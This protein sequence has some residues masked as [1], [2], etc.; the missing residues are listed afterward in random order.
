MNLDFEQSITEIEQQIADLQKKAEAD[1]SNVK[2]DLSSLQKKL[3]AQIKKVYSELTPWQTVQV[4]RHPERPIMRDY[5][6]GMF[7]EF[8]DLHGDRCFGDDQ[9]LVGGFA[10]IGSHRCVLIGMDKGRTV[11]EKIKANFGMSNPDGYR[12]ALR[13]MK[14]AEKYQIPVVSLVDTPAAYPGREAEERGQAEAI[15]RNLTE[16][17]GLKVPIVVTVTGE[18]GSGGALGIAVGD[19]VLM[20]SHSIYSVIPP[21]GCAAILWRDAEKAPEAAEALKVTAPSLLYIAIINEIFQV[22]VDGAHRDPAATFTATRSAIVKR[23]S[24]LKKLSEHKLLAQRREK[25]ARIGKY[26]RRRHSSH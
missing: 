2:S 5:I 17:A 20:L 21:E 4:A 24:K 25:Y 13:L 22:P 8:I 12:K 11:E 14:L 15:A 3:E 10:T 1:G 23:L 18:G 9:A 26:D 7:S 19:S 16:M 6:K